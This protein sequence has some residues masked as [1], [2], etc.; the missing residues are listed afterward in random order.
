[1]KYEKCEITIADNGPGFPA[2]ELPK[3]FTMFYRLPLHK[4]GGSGL[5]L[6][7]AKGFVEAHN[8]KIEV[9]S[10]EGNGA[11]FIIQLPVATSYIKNINHE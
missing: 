1:M 3:V 10:N 8:G 2:L 7:I 11:K 5:G 6:S 9:I 4:T